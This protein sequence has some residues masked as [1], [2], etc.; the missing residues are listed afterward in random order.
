VKAFLPQVTRTKS[1]NLICLVVARGYE[2]RPC[3]HLPKR[4]GLSEVPKQRFDA[5]KLQI[6]D[7][8]LG[9]GG[10]STG[11]NRRFERFYCLHLRGQVV[12]VPDPEGGITVFRNVGK[13]NISDGF[14]IEDIRLCFNSQN[15]INWFIASQHSIISILI[16]LHVAILRR[17]LMIVHVVVFWRNK[18]VDFILIPDGLHV[19]P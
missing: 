2:I 18:S 14:L 15:K 7:T 5:E 13:S 6:C 12:Q 11:R 10:A 19:R 9:H 16:W 4:S 3:S 1:S 17:M 8:G